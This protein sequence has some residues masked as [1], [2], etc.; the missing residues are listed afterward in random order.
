[1]KIDK[2]FEKIDDEFKQ[3]EKPSGEKIKHTLK[4]DENEEKYYYTEKKKVFSDA[5]EDAEDF[6][7]FMIQNP[8]KF[9]PNKLIRDFLAYAKKR[10]K[11]GNK[12]NWS[13]P[14]KNKEE[15][16]LEI[17]RYIQN[18]TEVLLLLFE[19]IQEKGGCYDS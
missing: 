6:E 14:T 16:D 12:V 9:F 2:L 18:S 19:F 8:R 15:L 1:M 13:H 10:Y 5:L 11:I 17:E 4:V 7:S 3:D